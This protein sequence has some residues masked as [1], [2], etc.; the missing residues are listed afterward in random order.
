MNIKSS[1]ISIT[2]L[3]DENNNLVSD[4][5]RISYIFNHYFSTIGSDIERKIATVQGSFK[6][7]YNKKDA[8]GKVLIDPLNS[9]FFLSLRVPGE[10]E[11]I[12]DGLDIYKS[13]VFILKSLK[14]FFSFWLSQLINVSF[15]VEIFLDILKIAKVTP[16]HKII[17]KYY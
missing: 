16:L 15:T 2:K 14:C 6:Y 17:I 9:S 12:I 8:N 11:R 4:P 7:Y 13:T 1:K 3:L 10:V 5:R